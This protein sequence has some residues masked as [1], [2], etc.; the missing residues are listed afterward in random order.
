[1]IRL[2]I[3]KIYGPSIQIEGPSLGRRSVFITLHQ[4]GGAYTLDVVYSKVSKLIDENTMLVI[5]GYEPFTQATALSELIFTLRSKSP[6][7]RIEVETSGLAYDELLAQNRI[8]FFNVNVNTR[9][10]NIDRLKRL[11]QTNRAIFKF[12]VS[13][14]LDIIKIQEI[15]NDIGAD[16][17]KIFIMTSG[18]ELSQKVIDRKWNLTYRI[19]NNV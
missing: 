10:F 17:T 12:R 2:L 6:L 13:N 19:E 3:E 15:I 4:S 14:E 9:D 5:N 1:M 11:N 7:S 16:C 18:I 8:A